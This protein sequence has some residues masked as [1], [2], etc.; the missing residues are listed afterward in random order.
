MTLF[1]SLDL[2]MD[3]TLK[4]NLL[5][6]LTFEVRMAEG[7]DEVADKGT[8]DTTDFIASNGADPIVYLTPDEEPEDHCD[9][10]E[11]LSPDRYFEVV[12]KYNGIELA[13][14]DRIWVNSRFEYIVNYSEPENQRYTRPIALV[15]AKYDV[16]DNT[17][18]YDKDL[19]GAYGIV[20]WHPIFYPFLKIELGPAA[21][22]SENLL[23]ST[24]IHE[25]VH[26]NQ[27]R[28][29]ITAI[30]QGRTLYDQHVAAGADLSTISQA[31][32]DS[33]GEWI[34]GESEAYSAEQDNY[35]ETCLNA[36]GRAEVD[37]QLSDFGDI[38]N[39]MYP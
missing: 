27:G 23:A 3:D 36:S 25:N 17:P 35:Q 9:T 11:I 19:V 22:E 37:R 6:G 28:S 32:K 13:A 10:L 1:T 2:V 18:Q 5:G 20:R 4:Q 30:D 12:A 15:G 33:I 7:H 14:S 8:I 38:L 26:L 34:D 24:W 16:P 31:D 21:Y 29:V 39:A